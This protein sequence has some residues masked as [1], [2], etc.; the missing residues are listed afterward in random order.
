MRKKHFLIIVLIGITLGGIYYWG[1]GFIYGSSSNELMKQQLKAAQYQS[2]LIA[3]MITDQLSAGVP[4]NK[5]IS[6]LQQ[7]LEYSSTDPVFICMFDKEGKEIC[8]PDRKKVGTRVKNSYVRSF[9][10]ISLEE[11]FKSVLQKN[12]AYGGIRTMPDKTEIIYLNPVKNTDWIVAS[13]S[14]LV[15]L[16]DTLREIKT[17]F[18]LFFIL[19][20]ICSVALILLLISILY[21]KYFEKITKENKVIQDEVFKSQKV[22]LQDENLKEKNKDKTV[23][24][25]LAEKGVKLV[26]VEVENIAFIYLENKI[27]YIIDF[28]GNK[29]TLNLALEEIYQALPK[30]LFFRVSRQIILSLKAIKNI[31]KYGI[32]QLRAVT[33]PSSEVPIII[34]KGKISEFKAWMGK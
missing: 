24:R 19:I 10:N 22:D 3:N 30:E 8:H 17:K 2:E 14:N 1:F 23:K 20:W 26:P 6:D 34:S 31:E 29:L 15:S 27:T 5:V 25:F 12:V 32:S 4:K 13:H 16:E 33:D 7:A 18:Q 11:N 9:S 21:Q 28:Q